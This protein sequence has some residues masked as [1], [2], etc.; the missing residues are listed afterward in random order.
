MKIE[1][2]KIKDGNRRGFKN[3]NESDFVDGKHEVYGEEVKKTPKELLI[4]EAGG[5]GIDTT[6]LTINQLKKAIA[7]KG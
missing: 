5:L 2:V 3:I 4:E 1:T 7:G 6:G